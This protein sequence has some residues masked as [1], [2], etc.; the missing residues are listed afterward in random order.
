[1]TCCS[2]ASTQTAWVGFVG[3]RRDSCP[4]RTNSSR[5]RRGPRDPFGL[6]KPDQPHGPTTAKALFAGP[7]R[8]R[9]SRVVGDRRNCRRHAMKLTG[10]KRGPDSSGLAFR[11]DLTVYNNEVL[12]RG[13]DQSGRP[14]LW[15]T[16]G[17]PWPGT[18]ETDRDR[19]SG[20]RPQAGIRSVWVHCLRRKW[21]CF[22]RHG[23]KAGP[24]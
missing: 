22:R 12:F 14:Q 19:G 1:M 15:V 16:N 3:D 24:R 23:F 13:L 7:R 10:N 17:K 21:C 2:T 9:R 5:G 6:L 8:Q 4:A 11:G 20:G 18:H